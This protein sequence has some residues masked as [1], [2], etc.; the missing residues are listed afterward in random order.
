MMKG[1]KICGV[2]DSKTLN[3]IIKH[4]FAPEFIGFICIECKYLYKCY[5]NNNETGILVTMTNTSKFSKENN[6]WLTPV[7]I[8]N[9]LVTVGGNKRLIIFNPYNIIS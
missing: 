3:F 4:P 2:S 5:S 6:I 8:N 1:S 9:K 7:L